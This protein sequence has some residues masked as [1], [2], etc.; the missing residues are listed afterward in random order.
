MHWHLVFVRH[1]GAQQ[2][3]VVGPWT[4]AGETSWGPDAEILW[5][6]FKL[7]TF[8]PDLPVNKCR[9]A[10]TPLPLGAFNS[11]WINGASWQFPDFENADLFV[12]KLVREDALVHDPLVT[13]TL[14]DDDVVPDVAPRTLRH[15]FLRATGLTYSHVRQAE[16]ARRAVTLLEQG[17]SIL[18]TV[19]E[20]GYYDQPH[21]TRSL[22]RFFGSTPA[23]LAGT[24]GDPR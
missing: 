2:V 4:A 6:K 13:T 21:L 20:A 14:H 18:D 16:R 3:L 24:S 5:I 12:K 19:F 22:Q 8:M 7:G 9:D 11:V 10:E 17:V 15:R 23:Q 1:K